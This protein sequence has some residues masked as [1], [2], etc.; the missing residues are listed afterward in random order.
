MPYDTGDIYETGVETLEAEPFTFESGSPDMGESPFDEVEE[1]E[2]ATQLLEV[3]EEAELDQFIGD[4]FRKAASA[5]GRVIK[6]PI[7]RQL[8]GMV[9][10]AIKKALPGVGAAIGGYLAPGAGA[11]VGSKL[12]SKAGDLLGLEL[13][14]PSLA[15]AALWAASSPSAAGICS[16][17]SWKV[18]PR[19]TGRWSWRS[20]W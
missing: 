6:S 9:K 2:Y 7:G 1:M 4:L 16:G 8:G 15:S 10:G 11:A 13:A 20:G 14:A 3:T 19:T 18:R 12:A 17:S 5:A